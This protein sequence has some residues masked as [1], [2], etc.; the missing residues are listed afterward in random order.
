MYELSPTSDSTQCLIRTNLQVIKAM[1]QIHQVRY[2][3]VL[4]SW[5]C[6]TQSA[7]LVT[8]ICIYNSASYFTSSAN[9]TTRWARLYSTYCILSKEF[10][11]DARW[12][13]GYTYLSKSVN[14]C[15]C[16]LFNVTV[17]GGWILYFETDVSVKKIN[18]SKRHCS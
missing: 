15:L 2:L 1:S 13:Q 11:A 4:C 10:T 5:V 16:Y 7:T 18:S 17:T 8:N 9:D 12:L 3:Y 6:I 14:F